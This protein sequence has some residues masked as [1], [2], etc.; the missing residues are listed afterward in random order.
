MKIV[1]N[2]LFTAASHS[3][4]SWTKES[5]KY[6]PGF[7]IGRHTCGSDIKLIHAIMNYTIN[8]YNRNP[9]KEH[10]RL[11]EPGLFK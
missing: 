4:T 11:K 5:G 2:I 6:I 10:L 8:L 7:Y 1:L 9:L 3:I